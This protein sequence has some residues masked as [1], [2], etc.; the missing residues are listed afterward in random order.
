MESRYKKGFLPSMNYLQKLNADLIFNTHFSTLYY[1]CEGRKRG[2]IN[3]DIVAYCPDPIIGKQWD[4]RVDLIGI[5]SLAGK[6][7][8]EK[9]RFEKGKVINIPFLIRK[10]V[11]QYDKGKCFYRKELNIPE[12]NFTVM[13]ADGAY[14][15]GKIRK[16]VLE[17]L[18][19]K[20]RF[21]ILA[22]C[23]KNE[24]LYKEFS[25]LKVPDNITFKPFGFT[26]KMLLLSACCD[27]FIGK[28][29]ASNLAEACYFGAPQI[30][31]FCATPIEKW[32]AKHYTHFVKSA[33]KI[34]DI[35]KVIK[36]VREW[37]EYPEKMEPYICACNSQHRTDGADRMA[38]ILWERLNK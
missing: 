38:E 4:S 16:T 15:A 17:L 12:D 25:N 34:S 29:G 18:K 36:K 11:E 30:I 7:K 23:G 21:T 20:E 31:T 33:V 3:S 1:A 32:I 19:L 35:R 9:S 37:M 13:L 27:V 6:N 24:N 28:A 5:S 8:A 22:V 26:D 10:E 14:G 2:L